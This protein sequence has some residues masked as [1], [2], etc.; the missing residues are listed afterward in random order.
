MRMSTK[1]FL[2]VVW[3]DSDSWVEFRGTN[4]ASFGDGRVF[5]IMGK[6]RERASLLDELEPTLASI[7]H[8]IHFL[9]AGFSENTMTNGNANLFRSF[10]A[11]VDNVSS[12]KLERRLSLLSKHGVMPTIVVH[13]GWGAHLYWV[14]DP[15]ETEPS[16][17]FK[18]NAFLSALA[19]GD[20]A[21]SPPA[22]PLRLPGSYNC[23]LPVPR[24][25]DAFFRGKIFSLEKLEEKTED[26]KKK[27]PRNTVREREKK[28]EETDENRRCG[29][30]G[31]KEFP[32]YPLP[33]WFDEDGKSRFGECPVL[34]TALFDPDVLS[35]G[36]WLSLAGALRTI[37][38]P[39]RGEGAF[40]S[41]SELAKGKYDEREAKRT[42]R[43]VCSRE[44]RAW[45]CSKTPEGRGCPM[46]RDDDAGGECIG[47]LSYLSRILY[48]KK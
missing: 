30:D 36:A 29:Q 33:V 40:L 31:G 13:S 14:V 18:M 12:E 21:A 27:I 17:A 22:H 48:P 25:V 44:M 7:P 8:N 11:D 1:D 16:K 39:E 47:L 41:L 34:K 4:S 15:P 28:R 35:Y 20:S 42:W 43:D 45:R 3:G 26:I 38:G 19:G 5:R 32:E 24:S 10:W 6:G 23:K 37:Y 9:P 2:D 46:E